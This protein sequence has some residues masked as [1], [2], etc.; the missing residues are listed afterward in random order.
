MINYFD[1]G[2]NI[3]ITIKMML[4]IFKD[5]EIEDYRIF[6]LEPN[7]S[8]YQHCINLFRTVE[9]IKI[10]QCGIADRSDNVKLYHS[11][12]IED[13]NSL[14]KT[15]NNIRQDDFEMVK[16][17]KFSKFISKQVPSYKKDYNIIQANI[18]G[19]E[20]YLF[21][22][23]VDSGVYKDIDI[24][25]GEGCPYP[26]DLLKVSELGTFKYNQLGLLMNRHGIVFYRFSAY[27]L[28]LNDDMNGLIK[29]ILVKNK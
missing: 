21:N 3:G 28:E 25:C 29:K 1:I 15:K 2:S 10:F 12:G 23:L 6:G 27:R 20:W 14:F 26:V 11:G 17:V 13:G 19:S 16:V 8:S 4:D 9:K 24:F 22:D 7:Q 5:L 18:E